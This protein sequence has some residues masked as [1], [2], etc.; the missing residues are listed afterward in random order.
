ML[1]VRR[2]R[3]LCDLDRLGTIAAVAQARSYTASAV[4]QQLSALERE[5]G[6]A[7]L[8]RT[9]RRVTFTA[10]GQ[11][12]LRQASRVLAALEETDA[13]LAAVRTGPAGPLRIGAFP[14]AV[15]TLLPPALVALGRAH[16]ALE[17]MVTEVDPAHVPA[18]LRERR[19]DV[20]LLNDYDVAPGDVD[21][22]LGSVPLL[23]E[24]VF[25]AVPA[26]SGCD[27]L[28][29]AAGQP[30]ILASEGTLCHEVT[31][32]ACAAHGYT[33]RVRHRAD[34]FVTVLA[35]VGAGQGVSLVP[36]LA[37]AAPPAT[38]RL[39]ALPL[40]RRT[41]IA[42]RR[43]AANHPA[44]TALLDFFRADPV[45]HRGGGPADGGDG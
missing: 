1:D 35:L 32:R 2:L 34:D 3:L 7:L 30:W 44:I 39:I 41:R 15:R 17:L 27:S 11:V 38:V 19:L 9:G 13:A 24:T 18:A 21:D 22:D 45:E 8:E 16:P 26:G 40:R 42:F 12:L 10:A 20:G 6:I 33:P 43:G 37:A 31:V 28:A 29:A 4:S 23:D 14:T 5:A 36:E 25:L